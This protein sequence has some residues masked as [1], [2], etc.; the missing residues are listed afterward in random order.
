MTGKSKGRLP[1]AEER[2]LFV[3]TLKE[4]KA[5]AKRKPAA[6]KPAPSKP[7]LISPPAPSAGLQKPRRAAAGLDGNTAERLRRGQLDPEARLDLHGM[8]ESTAHRALVTFLRA[9][10]ARGLRLVLIVTGKGGKL[11]APDAPFDLELDGRARG[12]LNAMTPR[13]LAEPELAGF[14]ADVRSSHR[15]HGGAGALYVYLRK[16][17]SK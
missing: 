3:E 11:A 8:T 9:A 5:L 16:S 4:A 13:W 17:K 12:V 10:S 2:E 15:R 14:V 7:A 1:S 6:P